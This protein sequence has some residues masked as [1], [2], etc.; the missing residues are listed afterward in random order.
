MP[1][2]RAPRSPVVD[3][4][5]YA[6][7]RRHDL[8]LGVDHV[9]PVRRARQTLIQWCHRHGLRVRTRIVDDRNWTA[10]ITPRDPTSRL[11]GNQGNVD[12][13]L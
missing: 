9:Q 6:D 12:V 7:G 13:R 8:A 4:S 1:D 2:I 11:P 10:R 3:W 5:R